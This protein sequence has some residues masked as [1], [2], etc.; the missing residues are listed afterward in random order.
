[1]N[2]IKTDTKVKMTDISITTILSEHNRAIAKTN[3]ELTDTQNQ[4]IQALEVIKDAQKNGIETDRMLFDF[5][6]K[7]NRSLEIAHRNTIMLAIAVI[8]M[9]FFNIILLMRLH[10]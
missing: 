9:I 10:G 4:L 8:I 6:Q 3:T 5:A 1:M 7:T 2:E